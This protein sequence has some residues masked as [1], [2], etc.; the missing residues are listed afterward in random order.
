MWDVPKFRMSRHF[1]GVKIWVIH[2]PAC[3]SINFSLKVLMTSYKV[4]WKGGRLF[5]NIFFFLFAYF[6]YKR[7]FFSFRCHTRLFLFPWIDSQDGHSS[8]EHISHPAPN[9]C[10]SFCSG[11][12]ASPGHCHPPSRSPLVLTSLGGITRGEKGAY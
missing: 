7:S 8:R 1:E 10:C 6:T 4:K 5:F 9:I 12:T 11:S 2:F 3:H